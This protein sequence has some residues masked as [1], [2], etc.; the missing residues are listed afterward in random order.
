MPRPKRIGAY[1]RYL[2]DP[3]NIPVP[4]STVWLRQTQQ[5]D[6]YNHDDP[7]ANNNDMEN[8]RCCSSSHQNVNSTESLNNNISIFASNSLIEMLNS[9]SSSNISSNSDN[10]S[11]SL[12]STFWETKEMN[13]VMNLM[14]SMKI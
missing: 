2:R 13:F 8:D 5:R 14:S 4:R 11:I 3:T 1:K 6:I 7:N 9:S 12:N 10:E